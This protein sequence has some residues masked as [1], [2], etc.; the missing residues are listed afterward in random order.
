MPIS[1]NTTGKSTADVD[2]NSYIDAVNRQYQGV[3]LS[4]NKMIELA[5]SMKNAGVARPLIE[6]WMASRP[7]FELDLS[8]P[9]YFSKESGARSAGLFEQF[10]TFGMTDDERDKLREKG[11]F[12]PSPGELVTNVAG[13][14]VLAAGQ[15]ASMLNPVTA[16]MTLSQIGSNAA[17]Q[18]FSV[19]LGSTAKQTIKSIGGQGFDQ[20]QIAADTFDAGTL[21]LLPSF[22]TPWL[23]GKYTRTI[24]N[25]ITSAVY[26]LSEA[27]ASSAIR[28]QQPELTGL[29]LATG[30]A[31]FGGAVGGYASKAQE[32]NNI[33]LRNFQT[34]RDAGIE[35]PPLGVVDPNYAT[36]LMASTQA[37]PTVKN[38]IE[39]IAETLRNSIVNKVGGFGELSEPAVLTETVSGLTQKVPSLTAEAEQATSGLNKA[40]LELSGAKQTRA[41][42]FA[43]EIDNIKTS[44]TTLFNGAVA[45]VKTEAQAALDGFLN[46]FS[47]DKFKEATKGITPSLSAAEARQNVKAIAGASYDAFKKVSDTL[48]SAVP[49]GSFNSEAITSS[50]NS[51]LDLAPVEV[52]NAIKSALRNIPQGIDE[53]GNVIYQP[54]SKQQWLNARNALSEAIGVN[55]RAPSPADHWLSKATSAITNEMDAQKVAALG[56][57]GAAKWTEARKFYRSV[58]AF[59]DTDVR[60][61]LFGSNENS[62]LA[63]TLIKDISKNGVSS[64]SRYGRLL[65]SLKAQGNEELFQLNKAKLDDTLRRYVFDLSTTPE[66][67][68]SPQLFIKALGDMPRRPDVLKTLGFGDA[69][70][71]K[72]LNAALQQYPE[73]SKLTPAQM[74]TLLSLP[75]AGKSLAQVKELNTV[76]QSLAAQHADA[77]I[78]KAVAMEAMGKIGPARLA[79]YEARQALKTA[80]LKESKANEALAIAKANPIYSNF[81]NV[82]VNPDSYDTLFQTFFN[83]V[84]G[85]SSNKDIG[86]M[87]SALRNGTKENKQTADALA[88]RFLNDAMM[89]AKNVARDNEEA[90]ALFADSLTPNKDPASLYQRALNIFTPEQ[91]AGLRQEYKAA[92]V[93]EAYRKNAGV[94]GREIANAASVAGPVVGTVAKIAPTGGSLTGLFR[95]AAG[96]IVDG[97]YNLVNFAYS[98]NPERF[99]QTKDAIG[100]ITNYL[101][102]LNFAQKHQ[103]LN[104]NKDIA[105]AMSANQQNSPQ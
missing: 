85:R 21:A 3:A 79:L 86:T 53:A 67:T 33:L 97:K 14:A 24:G 70:T 16:E 15:V 19:Y 49:E 2:G 78:G 62:P 81:N 68:V 1:E 5:T 48:F 64:N 77:K 66:G 58:E 38:Q 8:N 92:K 91:V 25:G 18:A 90:I 40:I 7:S 99:I 37:N 44:K 104:Q 74:T 102:K 94:N 98:T 12:F 29:A 84:S 65:L 59:H 30:L 39:H 43:A 76:L 4:D 50:I 42:Q 36:K 61:L 89:K 35:A 60:Q 69:T 22:T 63:D 71:I 101:S 26:G 88:A 34:L 13:E 9:D 51:A 56:E 82:N 27:N 100:S 41:K 46:T 10:K 83:P 20:R 31:G 6:N 105:E 103:F 23:N 32:E 73:A 52:K 54:A 28:G 72:Q 47:A 95:G 57:E 75:G 93:I 80:G 55:A 17:K 87:M 45:K 96:L 11:V